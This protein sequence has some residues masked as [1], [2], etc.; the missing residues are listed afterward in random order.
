M[1]IPEADAGAV[2]QRI[3]DASLGAIDL[4]A[5]HLG[6]RLGWYRSLASDGPATADQLAERTSTHPRYAREWLE[7]QAVSGLL[8]LDD[9]EPPTFT[10][11]AGAAEVLTDEQSLNY[12]APLARIFVAATT[13]MPALLE[14][15]RTG[16]GVGWA[17]YGADARES[18][19]DMN[20]P[21]YEQVL[22]GALAS[23][24]EVDALLRTPGATIADVGCGGAWSTIALARAYPDA[25]LHGYDI[26]TATVEL[27]RS[28]VRER[29]DVAD[30]IT[31]TESDAAGIPESSYTAAFAFECIHDMPAPVDVL[32]AVR[33]AL[34]PGGAMIVMDEAV[35]D[36]FS[37]P[38]S[39][40]ERLMYGFSLTVCLPDGM[41]HTPSAGTG[42]VMRPSTL[43]GY[44]EA[45][46]F[47][48]MDVLPIEDFAFFRFYRLTV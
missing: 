44:A 15:Y 11:P 32:S 29:P 28:N 36:E 22:P 10:L 40:V 1:S 12:L 4:L 26:D 38:G 25:R 9:S 2:S 48:T 14:A 8:T 18:Q 34:V 46:G 5:V 43:R 6:D 13:Q 47:G 35:D 7:Q 42:T 17:Q 19:A 41:N 39:D 23:V 30:R 45:A 31:I 21:W 3:F 27:A 33:M 20:R 37:A 24:P 16:G